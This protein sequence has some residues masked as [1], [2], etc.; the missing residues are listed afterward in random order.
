VG[1][2]TDALRRARA[3]R[4]RADDRPPAP[5][6]PAAPDPPF[7]PFATPAP[8][9]VRNDVA[10]DRLPARASDHEIVAIPSAKSGDW[11]ARAVLI[12]PAHGIAVSF[13]HFAIR[14][15]SQ[16]EAMG[17][18]GV[19]VTSP[20]RREGKTTTACNLALALASMAAE[21]RVALVDLD[22]HRP[23]VARGLGIHPKVGLE[24]ALEGRASLASVRICTQLPALDVF[25][26]VDPHSQVH[27][28]LSSARFKQL[29]AT[30]ARSYDAVVVD[31]PPVLLLPDVALIVP[32]VETC[33]AVVRAG[34]TPRSAFREMLGSLP[35]ERLIGCFLNDARLPR[36]SRYGYYHRD[37]GSEPASEPGGAD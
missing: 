29:I 6:E 31:A 33:V 23:S 16:L 5:P 22:L 35:R 19:L 12:D 13:R 7:V 18:R 8:G 9:S 11:A 15:R 20:L 32:Q 24:R 10:P 34:N 3:E 30:L 21:G 4:S 27:E 1:E 28:L 25:A 17:A 2:I 26:A 14:V 36:H 37:A